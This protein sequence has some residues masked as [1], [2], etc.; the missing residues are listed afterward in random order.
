MAFPALSPRVTDKQVGW[1]GEWQHSPKSEHARPDDRD[2]PVHRRVR[3]EPKP[4]QADGDQRR[5]RNDGRQLVLGLVPG[6][7]RRLLA[8]RGQPL[9]RLV[10]YRRRGAASGHGDEE[11]HEGQ[12]DLPQVEA[13]VPAEDEGES[14]EEE[15]QDAEEDGRVDVEDEAHGL[16]DEQLEGPQQG[17]ADRLTDGLLLLFDR[18]FPPLV[19]CFLSQLLCLSL[20]QDRIYGQSLSATLML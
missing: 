2:N 12:A 11:A 8:A 20:Q 6:L 16:V 1:G 9:P 19:T 5:A 10:P 15:V 18:S 3:R 17:I 4:K 14:A 7:A 13:V